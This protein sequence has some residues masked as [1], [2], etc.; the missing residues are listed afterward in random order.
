MGATRRLDHYEP[1]TGWLPLFIFAGIGVASI[2]CGIGLQILQIIS[3]FKHR[4][5]NSDTT[6][7]PWNGRTLEWSTPSPPPIYNFAIIPEVHERD[8]FWAMKQT[9]IESTKPQYEDIHIPKDNPMGVLIAGFGFILCFALIWEITWLA[10]IGILGVIVFTIIR[11][12]DDDIEY[13]ISAEEVERME[14]E[15]AKKRYV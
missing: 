2:M 6:G 7:D 3:S 4:R 9:K 12:S 8:P 13:T 15:M 5:Q 14:A 10:W 1:S 11:L